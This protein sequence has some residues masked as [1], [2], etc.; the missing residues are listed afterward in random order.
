MVLCEIIATLR[1]E[2]HTNAK[3]HIIEHGIQAGHIPPPK[4]DGG[5]RRDFTPQDLD[6][7]R[8]YLRNV[9]PRGPRKATAT[10]NA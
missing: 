3:K 10:A 7:I 1:G 2:G 9:P 5:H 4:L 8:V 6:N